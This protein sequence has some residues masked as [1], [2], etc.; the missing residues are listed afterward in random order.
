MPAS[1]QR[2]VLPCRNASPRSRTATTDDLPRARAVAP[3][4][5]QS[6]PTRSSSI[7]CCRRARHETTRC[8]AK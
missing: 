7:D 5:L 6:H 2:A 1:E 4:A 3:S 8:G